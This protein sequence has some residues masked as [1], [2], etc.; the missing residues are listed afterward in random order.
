MKAEEQTLS[1][2]EASLSS[3]CELL[4]SSTRVHSHP[5]VDGKLWVEIL[6]LWRVNIRHHEG[7]QSR[8]AGVDNTQPKLREQTGLSVS[9]FCVPG[10]KMESI[11]LPG[12]L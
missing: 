3:I 8:W 5:L 6:N 9:K 2:L 11:G 7:V 12:T 1:L 4:M 10:S